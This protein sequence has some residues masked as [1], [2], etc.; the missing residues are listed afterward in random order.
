MSVFFLIVGASL[1]TLFIAVFNYGRYMLAAG[2]SEQALKA[3]LTSV[4]SYY[5]TT[6]TREMGLFALD[7]QDESLAEKGR[8]YFEDNLGAAGAVNGQECLSYQIGF[9]EE[10]RLHIEGILKT[11]ATDRQRV[12]AWITLLQDLLQ[13]FGKGDLLKGFAGSSDSSGFLEEIGLSA[14]GDGDSPA[15]L[16]DRPD[17]LKTMEDDAAE[18]QEG[19]GER[20]RFYH[21]LLPFPPGDV[22]VDRFMPQA[23]AMDEST[24]ALSE[25]MA[26]WNNLSSDPVVAIQ[27]EGFPDGAMEQ[28][29]SFLP[30]LIDGLSSAL[31]KGRDK[32]LLNDYFLN[33]LD[34]AT[35]KPVLNR[36][37][38]RCEV[39][40]V[41]NGASNSW[42]NVRLTALWIQ[43]LRVAVHFVRAAKQGEVKNLTTLGVALLKANVLAGRD[44]EKLFAG[45]RVALYPG[46]TISMSYKDYLRL[47]LLLKSGDKEQA[48][49]GRL[50]QANLWHWAGK[51]GGNPFSF[52]DDARESWE[53]FDDFALWRYA[54]EVRAAAETELSLW[55]IG[56]VRIRREGVMGYDKPFV[57]LSAK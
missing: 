26:Y 38:Q 51:S 32:I 22:F 55:P 34:F 43:L 7:T 2:Q 45:E 19:G 49:L 29:G 35:N 11:Q 40:Y 23:S 14:G 46:S 6:L 57:L 53:S 48:A 47:Y 36:Y 21:F 10:G 44:V 15:D 28:V 37:F 33:E 3:S 12:E 1:L 27:E 50:V 42:D 16:A 30:A 4:L 56:R 25:Q 39:E 31:A 13:F 52:I 5:E 54:T 24:R 17:W 8:A 9:P 20:L 18:R 41:I